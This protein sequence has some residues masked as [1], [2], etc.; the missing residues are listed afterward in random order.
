MRDETEIDALTSEFEDR[1]GEL[2]EMA[3]NLFYQ[4][5]VK[6]RAEKAGLSAISWESGQIV[7]RY[8]VSGEE[9][10][11]KRLPDLGPGIRGGKSAY[12]CS[13]GEKWESR[14]LETLSL[15]ADNS[16]VT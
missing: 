14:L 7:L 11:G 8:P 5:R 10:D 2:P 13:F 3:G 16:R 15:L 9:K 6:L 12:W 1:F 4:M